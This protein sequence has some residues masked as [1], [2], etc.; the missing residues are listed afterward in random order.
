M[1]EEMENK[2]AIRQLIK[3]VIKEYY[4]TEQYNNPGQKD[5]FIPAISEMVKDVLLIANTE[6]K[7]S[8]NLVT[9]ILQDDVVLNKAQRKVK[10]KHFDMIQLADVE[11]IYNQYGDDNE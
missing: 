7:P 11:T 6:I 8:S 4:E 9:R 10:Y 5:D 2:N 1:I 3:E